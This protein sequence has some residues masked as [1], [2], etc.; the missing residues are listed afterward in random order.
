MHEKVIYKT[1]EHYNTSNSCNGLVVKLQA[2]H[3]FRI[4]EDFVGFCVSLLVQ[5]CVGRFAL[6]EIVTKYN[7][8]DRGP[9]LL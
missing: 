8:I 6:V 4:F 2:D 1:K 3:F 5:L 9:Y 7:G